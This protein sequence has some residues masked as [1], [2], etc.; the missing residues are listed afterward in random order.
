MPDL[1]LALNNKWVLFWFQH[2]LSAPEENLKFWIDMYNVGPNYLSDEA[3][4]ALEAIE[5]MS[6]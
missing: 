5:Q 3:C 6:G 1:S 2:F 4:L